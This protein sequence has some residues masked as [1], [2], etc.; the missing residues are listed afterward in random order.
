MKISNLKQRF[1]ISDFIFPF[2]SG[3]KD[4]TM[5]LFAAWFFFTYTI[6]SGVFRK[7]V[8]GPGVA[9]N[10]IFL[11]QLVLPFIFFLM[12]S[13]KRTKSTFKIP[14][15]FIFYL[16]YLV[17]AAANPKNHTIYH[18]LF[19]I[20]IHL[21]IW[22]GLIA[23][24]KK[25]DYFE[26]ENLVL[27]FIVILIIEIILA[28]VQYSLPPDH[29]L[30]IKGDGNTSDALVGEA[31]R[32]SGTFSY[33]GGFHVMITF[34]GF[35]IW[36]LIVMGFPSIIIVFVFGLSLYGALMSG[37][38]GAMALL[39]FVSGFSFIYTGFLFKRIL[40]LVGTLS[41]LIVLLFYLGDNVAEVVNTSYTNFS[42]R[43]AWG[44]ESGEADT[45]LSDYVTEVVDYRGKYPFYGIGLGSTYQGA[46]SLFGESFYSKEYGLYE[47]EWVRIVI[48]GGFILFFL[49]IFSMLAFLYYSYIPGVAKWIILAFYL[50]SVTTFNTYQSVFFFFG[51]ILVDRAYL[52][53]SRTKVILPK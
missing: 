40:N 27:F 49:R 34:Y 44:E 14:A 23:Y 43:V 21:G 33:L 8:F 48:E 39:L 12:I 1:S 52:L 37:S 31:V 47:S 41:L 6:F 10:V 42:E 28:S 35:L 5:L 22:I 46:N 19:G 24:Y 45:R 13:T 36:Y 11:I 17:I 26:L 15:L 3:S 7:W 53:K 51:F 9:N 29:I 30:N 2:R 20:V 50:G 18:G 25:R 38:R 16:A 4:S 32:V